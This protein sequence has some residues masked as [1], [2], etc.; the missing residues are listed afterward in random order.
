MLN[1]LETAETPRWGALWGRGF[2][3]FFLGAGLYAC[4][5]V[6][7]WLA[8]YAGWIS[9]PGW[10]GPAAWH[11]HEMIFGIV[12]AAVS[13]F[14]LTSVPVWTR[15]RP[16]EGGGLAALVALW[17]AG[18]LAM[19]GAGALSP[20]VVAL[21]DLAFL[22]ALAG[23]LARPLIRVGQVGNLGFLGILA[24]LFGSN[25]VMHAQ[26]RRHHP[27]RSIE[28]DSLRG[29]SGDR[30]H[31]HR[32][33]TDHARVYPKRARAFGH[34]CARTI[35][36]VARPSGRRVRRRGG[37]RGPPSP[38]DTLERCDLT[39]SGARRMRTNERLA[40][41]S[42]PGRSAPLV[43][44]RGVRLGRRRSRACGDR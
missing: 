15:A 41:P 30:P 1:D 42:D 24:A 14:L 2:R 10:L 43:A 26:A 4:F 38:S 19:L 39:R 6:P 9:P 27:D 33:R 40:D 31:R 16:V 18:R 29:G 8:V 17:V 36:S 7:A 5:V 32:G 20:M 13:G 34:P 28:R 44:A 3:P 11:G 25:L 37:R 21:V 22:P 35:P 23:V 12:V